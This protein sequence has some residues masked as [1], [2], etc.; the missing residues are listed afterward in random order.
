MSAAQ[1]AGREIRELHAL[2]TRLAYEAVRAGESSIRT[3]REQDIEPI[4]ALWVAVGSP[5]SVTDTRAGLASL[6]A[7]DRAGRLVRNPLPVDSTDAPLP[8]ARPLAE[9]R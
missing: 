8:D 4:P 3:A 9:S 6:L 2:E 1:T 5:P 7:S